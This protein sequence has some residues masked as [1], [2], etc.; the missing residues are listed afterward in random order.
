M[1]GNN[2]T[3]HDLES[4]MRALENAR[5]GELPENA[6]IIAR[7]DG[8]G[9]SKLTNKHFSKPF[10]TEFH[11]LMVET[12]H[13]LLDYEPQIAFAY[14]QSDEISV[15]IPPGCAPFNRKARKL[16]SLL[17]AAASS[18]FSMLVG[19]AVCFDCRLN[20]QYD[21]EGVCNYFR[22]RSI[23]AERNAFNARAYWLLRKQG[24]PARAAAEQL[25]ALSSREHKKLLAEHHTG[26]DAH[27][28][29]QTRGCLLHRVE[30][31][32]TGYNPISAQP[33]TYT[34]RKMQESD[35]SD[36]L[37]GYL[38]EEALRSAR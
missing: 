5:E 15:L 21:E 7:L 31:N 3:F 9:F 4:R 8:R 2:L 32:R 27:P 28:T 18:K 19:E 33:T 13:H 16:L 37:L 10:D 24:V 11:R 29:W 14:N 36:E 23:D 26:A 22:W 6:Y 34:R 38:V 25:R 30:E 35:Y 17:A 1:D 12:M 20:L